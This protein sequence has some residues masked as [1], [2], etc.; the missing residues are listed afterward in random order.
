MLRYS[1]FEE[2]ATMNLEKEGFDTSDGRKYFIEQIEKN[3][4]VIGLKS[5]WIRKDK[6]VVYIS[7]SSKAIRDSNGKTLYY[8]G[9]VEDITERKRVEEAI[10]E[11]EAK[12][13]TMV[14]QSPNGIFIMDLSGSFL[15]VNKAMCDF[16]KYSE[17]EILSM[18]IGDIVPQ[19]Y[20]SLYKN[21]MATLLKGESQK[22]AAE[23]AVKGKDGI[24]Q[25]IE[26]VSAP[27][28][29]NKEI[30][31]IQVNSRDI[32]ERKRAEEKIT[33]LAHSLKSINECVCITDMEDKFIFVNESFLKTYGYDENELIGKYMTIVRS[34]NNSP[35]L[36]KE[37]LPATLKGG[38]QGELWNKRKD[39]SEFL[40]FLS[41][42][43]INDKEGNPIGL[44][45]VATDITE[46]KRTEKELINAK[47][48]AEE[49]DKL[50]SE[51]LA[52]M[53]HEIR[54][55][56]NAIVGNVDY[57]NESFGKKMDSDARECFEGIELAS[58]R[59]IRTVDL[60]LNAAEL[61]TSSY[62]QHFVKVDLNSEILNKLYQ[63]HQLS[64]K[65][66]GLEFIY[67][68]TEK[69]TYV[70]ADEYSITQIFAN[71]IDNAIKYTK[72]GKVEILL[73]KNKTNNIIVEVKDTG[74]GIS[75]EFLPRI[76]EVFAQEEH[77]YSRSF[78]GNGLGLT[79]VKK[80]C[81]LNKIIMEVDSE[82]NI[83]STFRVIFDK[84]V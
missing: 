34:L 37:I 67:T 66:K 74:I 61:Q 1:S 42:T 79:L 65:K 60:V 81:E 76:F 43:I 28:Y 32:T 22:E 80:Y 39:G 64:A 31:G 62:K 25:F 56:I 40:I 38:W 26:V 49:S 30:I 69:D 83:G 72:K 15:S 9:T 68:C 48:K 2:L 75:K 36:V 6:T 4:E 18:K 5:A 20:L 55:P 11:S 19:E 3:G 29:K 46:R 14:T 44:I 58:K 33:F 57:L 51:F 23:Y 63:E 54:T 21:R 78:D 47:E 53:S 84:K 7:E 27:Y 12:Y 13:R 41:T 59:I 71:L 35:E 73:G 17:E 77:G 82:K 52:Q 45:G 8:D 24:V 70:I 50:K 16:L 10:L